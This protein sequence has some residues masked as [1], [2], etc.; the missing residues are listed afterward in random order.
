[1]FIE[2][3][4]HWVRLSLLQEKHLRAVIESDDAKE[5]RYARQIVEL[6]LRLQPEAKITAFRNITW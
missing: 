1:M 4:P 5:R 3:K 6:E 2:K